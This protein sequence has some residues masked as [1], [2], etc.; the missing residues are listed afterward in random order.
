MSMADQRARVLACISPGRSARAELEAALGLTR[1]LG[2]ILLAG[3]VRTARQPQTHSPEG[4][5][6][7]EN[8]AFAETLGATIVATEA[9]DVPK[10]LIALACREHVTH[11]VIGHAGNP[12]S[13]FEPGS[14]VE[15][16][17]HACPGTEIQVVSVPSVAHSLRS[18]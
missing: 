5:V 6:L 4:Q 16:F 7:A 10:G 15:V 18:S 12:Q 1:Q 14:I 2:G 13:L 17:V 3:Y 11:A 8:V 9:D